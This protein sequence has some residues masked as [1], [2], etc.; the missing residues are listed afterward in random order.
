MIEVRLF[1]AMVLL[2]LGGVLFM[3]VWFLFALVALACALTMM[4]GTA[5][6][7]NMLKGQID[8]SQRGRS[9]S[10]KKDSDPA[11][12]ADASVFWVALDVIKW[13]VLS[14]W[15]R[16]IAPR[17]FPRS[18]RFF[19]D[20]GTAPGVRGLVA[21]TIDDAF[22]RQADERC[23]LIEP[24]RALLARHG[25]KA[26][27]FLTLR[28]S[29]G[30]WRERQIAN[31]VAD[32]HE[33][34]NHCED[35]R[36]YDQDS[37]ESFERALDLTEKFIDSFDAQERPQR[38]HWP[39]PARD[40]SPLRRRSH[41]PSSRRHIEQQQAAAVPAAAPPSLV[42][43]RWFRAPSASL[44]EVMSRVLE[45][46]GYTHV[47]TDSYANDPH[48]PL[49]RWLAWAMCRRATHGS[50]LVLHMPERGFREWDLEAIEA[51]LTRLGRRGLRSVTLTELHAA[52]TTS[53]RPSPSLSSRSHPP[54]CRGTCCK[55]T[56]FLP[57]LLLTLGVSV[58]AAARPHLDSL[59]PLVRDFGFGG[60]VALADARSRHWLRLPPPDVPRLSIHSTSVDEIVRRLRL[61]GCVVVEDAIDQRTRAAV[62]RELEPHFDQETRGIGGDDFGGG[63]APFTGR[64]GSVVR[65]SNASHALA[66][67]PLLLGAVEAVLL[68]HSRKVQ[69]KVMETIRMLPGGSGNGPSRGSGRSRTS[70]RSTSS[71]RSLTSRQTTEP[72]MSSPAPTSGAGAEAGSTTRCRRCERRCVP[73][74]PFSSRAA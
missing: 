9:T 34:A 56:W 4:C 53:A 45:R 50:I 27:F 14:G 33:L 25:A 73:A 59:G 62:L 37:E 21:L 22:C 48:V 65:K 28:Y 68:P 1:F 29:K 70:T 55:S 11:V 67:Q 13:S 44:S 24:L 60:L 31:L 39:R 64:V 72:R 8:H 36:E 3:L 32:R 5:R 16:V 17:L 12:P 20:V 15:W 49:P 41:S 69:A 57:A 74:P 43:P 54:S 66:L 30:A 58:G 40:R 47:L 7:R 71:T 26:T 23:S 61:S 10:W 2:A 52:A 51:V 35:D 42:R 18:T 6:V 46:R 63:T 19:Y 38:S